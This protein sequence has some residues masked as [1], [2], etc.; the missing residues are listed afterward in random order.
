[1][2]IADRVAADLSAALG[3]VVEGSSSVSA[4]GEEHVFRLRDLEAP[5]GLAVRT[6]VGWHSL[7]VKLELDT[8]AST[9]L[10]AFGASSLDMRC[11]S[12]GLLKGMKSRGAAVTAAVDGMAL[13]L[14]APAAWPE[15]WKKLTLFARVAPIDLPAADRQAAVFAWTSQFLAAVVALLPHEPVGGE[16]EGGATRVTTNKYERSRINRA[17]CIAVRG[18]RCLVCGVDFG[19]E[20]GI[21]GEGFIEVHHL[22]PVSKIP[23]GTPIN[24]VQDLA[25]VCANCHAMLHRRTPPLSLDELRAVTRRRTLTP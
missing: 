4:E 17:A 11:E 6:V 2:S 18:K 13:E 16:V 23:E 24:P 15:R 8:F 7:E 25:P 21:L 12:A 3:L 20:Y 19:E 1:M 5:R 10:A 14:D 9:V 22:E